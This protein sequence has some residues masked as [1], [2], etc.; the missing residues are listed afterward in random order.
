MSS[1]VD[2]ELL[3]EYCFA[4]LGVD[5]CREELAITI[6]CSDVYS[7]PLLGTQPSP[8]SQFTTSG[9]VQS[10]G[11]L[12]VA[13]GVSGRCPRSIPLLDAALSVDGSGWLAGTSSPTLGLASS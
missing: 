9:V 12:V 6:Q 10:C 4:V 13:S 1:V 11:C 2:V 8:S 5:K 7:M 3:C